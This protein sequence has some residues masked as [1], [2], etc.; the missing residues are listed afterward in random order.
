[1]IDLPGII[2]KYKRKKV[3]KYFTTTDPDKIESVSARLLLKAFKRVSENVPAYKDILNKH[4]LDPSK[5]TSVEKF[6]EFV[7]VVDKEL[8]F[9]NYNIH[10]LCLNGSLESMKTA[11]SSSGFSG[12]FSFG[13][14]T[15]NDFKKIEQSLD[16]TFDYMFGISE[17]R[18]FL[19]STVAMG[20]KVSSSL[21]FA[22]TSV[23]SD[24]ALAII[25]KFMPYFEQL[26]LVGDPYFIKK[27]LEEGI[28]ENI[29]WKKLNTNILF[30]GDWFSDSY[31]RYIEYL[32]GIDSEK[33]DDRVVL[34]T[35]GIT[36]LDLNIFHESAYT[37][38]IRKHAQKNKV[39]KDALF[40]PGVK[41]TP[42]L[43]HYF[44]HRTYMESIPDK[45]G[46]NELVFS[47]LSSNLLMPFVRYN[48][49]D[50]GNIYTYNHVIDVLKKYDLM[51]LSPD[52][53][54][55]MVT[56]GG[57]N[58][59]YVTHGGSKI[60]AEDI[61]Q[62]LFE[63]FD[64]ARQI[65]AC[66]RLTNHNDEAEIHVQLNKNVKKSNKLYELIEEYVHKYLDTRIHCKIYEYYEYPFNMEL[67]YENK[68]KF[69]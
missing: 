6:K 25:K 19:V 28:Q 42:I 17:K 46:N 5:I 58:N 56:V 60:F 15:R 9:T 29:D 18:T 24:I 4:E 13:I 43:F 27:V 16:T 55:P 67:D 7:P 40:G 51:H 41:T 35:M 10:E 14:S 47:M 59:R 50:A 34:A 2:N 53:K 31:R 63:N 22:E 38:A 48:S 20:V 66:F 26:I 68:L 45:H 64:V 30:G 37:V 21:A 23:R 61:K 12:N 1:M 39:L 36:E 62:G 32:C 11:M 54:L 57:R 69:I 52:L 65:S 33:I 8:L 49:K 44:P 3:I